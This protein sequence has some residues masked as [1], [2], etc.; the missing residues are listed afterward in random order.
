[1]ILVLPH[2]RVLGSFGLPTEQDLG[3]PQA[4]RWGIPGCREENCWEEAPL[5]SVKRFHSLPSRRELILA[6]GGEGMCFIPSRA[7]GGWF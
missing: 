3:K 1:M 2:H 6:K 7:S 5:A 4:C